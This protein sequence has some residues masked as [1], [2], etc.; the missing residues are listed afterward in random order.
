MFSKWQKKSVFSQ[1]NTAHSYWAELWAWHWD[2][3]LLVNLKIC[4]V[5]HGGLQVLRAWVLML[6]LGNS[7]EE[8]RQNNFCPCVFMQTG[9]GNALMFWFCS[10]WEE[11][12]QPVLD[13]KAQEE[14]FIE[15][16]I[17][18]EW[19]RKFSTHSWEFWDTLSFFFFLLRRVYFRENC[20]LYLQTHIFIL[21]GVP[22]W[23]QKTV[24][25]IAWNP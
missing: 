11:S 10:S 15:S 9:V 4:V 14:D 2:S 5:L 25:W 17:K 19:R 24:I 20:G 23:W 3:L 21:G 8:K 22:F 12:D 16:S 18:L 1:L 6:C 13:Y 7:R